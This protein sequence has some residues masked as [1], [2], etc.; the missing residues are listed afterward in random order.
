MEKPSSS[1]PMGFTQSRLP[2]I[3]ALGAWILFL[4]TL[5]RW[6]TYDGLPALARATGWDWRMPLDTPLEFLVTFPVRW[7]PHTWQ[8]TGLNLMAVLFAAGTLGLLA[9]CIALLPH[10]RTKEQRQLER[11]DY[12]FLTIK[13]AWMPPILAVLVCG[14]QLTFW[15]HAV[16]STG[17]MLNLFLFAFV[18]WSLLEYRVDEREW[19]L[20]LAA[21]VYGAAMTNNYAMIGFLPAFLVALVWIRGLAF[22]QVPFLVRMAVA[23]L[24]GLSLYLVLPLIHVASG[25]TH[26]GFG[27]AL[28]VHLG[29]QKNMLLGFPRYLVVIIGL[30]S[31]APV[32]FIGIRWKA[33]VGDIS[34]TG[35]NLTRFLTMVVH[36][37][38]LV[39]CIVLAF[40]PP[41][42]P[43]RLGGGLA[44]L[45]FYFLS[46]LS[47]GYFAGYFL[48]VC[49]TQPL[50]SW[51]RPS[52]VLQL[53]N[54]ALL[55]A[56]WLSLP[57]VP[58]LLVITNYP[59]LQ[60]LTGKALAV[61]GQMTVDSLPEEPA[62]VL[63]DD[64]GRLN[65]FLAAA[66]VQSKLGKVI[67][68]DTT[69]LRFPGYHRWQHQRHPEAWPNRFLNEDLESRLTDVQLQ[70][71]LGDLQKQRPTYYMHP[72]FGFY[73]EQFYVWSAKGMFLLRPLPD[74]T[75]V[76]PA[77]PLEDLETSAAFLDEVFAQ[78]PLERL[79]DQVARQVRTK[80][81]TPLARYLSQIFA[82]TYDDLGVR[83]QRAG[84]LERA[85]AFFDMALAL[86]PDNVTAYIN[87]DFNAY[88]QNP[89]GDP[90][91][92]SE[93]TLERL[94]PY[95]G[96]WGRI[97]GQNGPVDEPNSCFLLAQ[98][99]VQ[100]RNLVQAAQLFIRAV[101][102]NSKLYPAQIALAGL[103]VKLNRPDDALQLIAVIRQT[104]DM[105]TVP[106]EAQLRLI[107]AEAWAVVTKGDFEKAKAMLEAAQERYPQENIP[108]SSLANLYLVRGD[109]AS[110]IQVYE[111]QL[112]RQS[113]NVPVQ[114][115][116]SALYITEGGATDKAI[117]MLDRAL[118]LDPHNL[119]ALI[120]RA[121]ANYRAN[122]LSAARRDY[123]KVLEVSNKPVAAAIFG[124][125][126]IAR[127]EKDYPT[128]LKHY[129][130]FLEVAPDNMKELQ[131][132][133]NYIEQIENGTL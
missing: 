80:E 39:S 70:A 9:R 86:S 119:G 77:P 55:L 111:T 98:V 85:N 10:D 28:L 88:L 66:N 72:S 19:R 42:G 120:N 114:I 76:P 25:L 26:L 89:S 118:A 46:S 15:Q 51:E 36:G 35:A 31:L 45:P 83:L 126:E 30:T 95:G 121:I 11:S 24:I 68:V 67:P 12:S 57:L 1:T 16:V 84:Q 4:A 106:L 22:F 116:L 60:E 78:K 90:P 56:V 21:L 34:A 53:L 112:S 129:R 97:L 105:T 107:E 93:G 41:F 17:E 49:G 43:R 64:P 7:L 58:A 131:E 100:G 91:G 23:G 96:D 125:A 2:W 103:Y 124:L 59:R 123:E 20:M 71:F 104:V 82:M 101:E 65:A 6:A 74:G 50:K 37:L 8:L 94:K 62:F 92:P 127:R 102:L 5:V 110:A 13:A 128:A 81:L 32:L 113:N 115:N 109:R 29:F 38:F 133:R 40:D 69:S 87:R 63:S 79:R 61:Y 52:P 44:F 75:V 108:Y 117:A 3:L 73:F 130:R 99:L 54:R 33:Q 132:A 47:V 14:L 27:D 48:L 122:N 18:V